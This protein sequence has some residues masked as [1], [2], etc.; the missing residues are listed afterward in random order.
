MSGHSKWHSIKHKKAATDAKR[1]KIFTRMIKEITIAAKQGGGDVDSNPR[2][3]TA[4]DNAKAAN[5]P[6]DNIKK[7]VLRGTGEL[8]GVNYEEISYEGYGP[9]G[10]AII[11]ECLTDNKNRTVAEVRHTLGKYNGNLGESGCV[12]WMF[13]KKGL[14]LVSKEKIEEDELMEIILE[15]G[16]ED[17][18]DDD[19]NH[20]VTTTPENLS[21]V[22]DAI[23]SKVEI[24]SSEIS[25]I[26]STYIKLEEKQAHQM[27]KLLDKIEEIDDVQNLWTNFDIDTEMIE[28]Y[29][30]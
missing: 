2:L 6:N 24:L 19:D 14:I 28:S 1:G 21:Q 30:S 3:R 29:G 10:V 26:P 13:S 22:T 25:M 9:G 4:I 11:I 8:E 16:A 12:G 23:K 5:M 20:I 17:L 7:A 18:T 27:L 15:N